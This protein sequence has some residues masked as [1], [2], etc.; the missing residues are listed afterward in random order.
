LL[1]GARDDA[2]VSLSL[3]VRELRGCCGPVKQMKSW[4]NNVC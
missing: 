4:R 2:D 3:I 1:P